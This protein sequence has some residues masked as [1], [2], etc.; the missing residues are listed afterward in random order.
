M[1]ESKSA[2]EKP[3]FPIS[4]VYK[5]ALVPEGTEGGYT[6]LHRVFRQNMRT[7][8]PVFMKIG[9]GD[10]EEVAEYHYKPW[11]T[12]FVEG[13]SPIIR[14]GDAT[15][16]KTLVEIASKFDLGMAFSEGKFQKDQV[17]RAFSRG[18]AVPEN[19][20]QRARMTAVE[21]AEKIRN[22]RL[23]RWKR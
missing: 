12:S 1:S 2:V 21:L 23:N 20:F 17:D 19:V 15:A 7:G 5:D 13:L 6:F 14:K 11:H 4:D 10:N 3:R 16:Y 18:M 9:H 8:E 22:R